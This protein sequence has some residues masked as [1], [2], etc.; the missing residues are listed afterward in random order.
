V[1][2]IHQNSAFDVVEGENVNTQRVAIELGNI[3]QIS[4]SDMVEDFV[5]N[6]KGVLK[7]LLEIQISV[8]TMPLRKLKIGSIN[9]LELD[10][11]LISTLELRMLYPEDCTRHYRIARLPLTKPLERWSFSVAVSR[12]SKFTWKLSLRKECPG[13]ITGNGTLTIVVLAHASTYRRRKSRENAFTTR[14]CNHCGR[15]TT[16]P[17]AIVTNPAVKTKN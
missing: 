7:R 3:P 1:L 16:S 11:K 17:K 5:V 10:D 4:A 2:L 8:I 15:R 9:M 6:T 14:I 12:I 13:R